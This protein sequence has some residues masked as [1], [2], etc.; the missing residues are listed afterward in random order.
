MVPAVAMA[1]DDFLGFG[2]SGGAS[3]L[4]R[5]FAEG[6]PALPLAIRKLVSK[7]MWERTLE[8]S[9]PGVVDGLFPCVEIHLPGRQALPELVQGTQ[10]GSDIRGEGREGIF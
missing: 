8:K 7:N 6:E 1:K 9:A 5:P 3:V 10:P 4:G 2:A